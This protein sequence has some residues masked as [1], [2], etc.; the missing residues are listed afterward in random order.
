[1][2]PPSRPAVH[3]A[4]APPANAGPGATPSGLSPP[5]DGLYEDERRKAAIKLLMLH[6][7]LAKLLAPQAG[8]RCSV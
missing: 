8:E 1:M 6:A 7:C 2:P 5:A 4:T 3:A